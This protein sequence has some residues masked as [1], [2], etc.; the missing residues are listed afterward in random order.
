MNEKIKKTA[1]ET[2]GGTDEKQSLINS[3]NI[4]TDEDDFCNSDDLFAEFREESNPNFIR[5]FTLGELFDKSYDIKQPIIKDL[6]YP[7]M[8]LFVG[9]PK[10]GKSFAMLQ[11]A[12]HVSNGLDLWDK[13]V[14]QGKVVYLALEDRE[15]RIVSRYYNM[16]GVHQIRII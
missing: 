16:F 12:H 14:N 3:N 5:T 11:I 10:I 8:Y 7:G 15:P 2:S 13:K 6:L 9:A 1:F 4:I